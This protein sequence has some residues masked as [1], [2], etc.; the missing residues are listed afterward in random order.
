MEFNGFM[1][2]MKKAEES[3]GMAAVVL[4][5][6]RYKNQI[7][8]KLS[9][10]EVAAMKEFREMKRNFKSEELG[11]TDCYVCYEDAKEK[12]IYE[13]VK[14]KGWMCFDCVNN[15]DNNNDSKECP[16]CKCDLSVY[17]LKNHILLEAFFRFVM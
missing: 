7:L 14:C 12:E 11:F 4:M 17:K 8:K 15:S 3:D 10:T 5:A 13:C 6:L 1:A 2:K 16:A 9:L